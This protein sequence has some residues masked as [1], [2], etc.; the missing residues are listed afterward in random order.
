[1]TVDLE[2]QS[3]TLPDGTRAEFAV[4][5]FA[6]YCLLNGVDELA[7]LLDQDAAIAEFERRLS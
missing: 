4:E 2:T 1:M 7:F 5:P 6:R 3:V